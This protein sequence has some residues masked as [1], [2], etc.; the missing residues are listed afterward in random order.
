MSPSEIDRH[1]RASLHQ[2][3]SL[4]H[5]DAKLLEELE[6]DLIITQELCRVCA[7]SYDIV[8]RAVKRLRTDTRIV[9]LEPASLEDVFA[10]ISWIGEI[11]LHK[12]E[13]GALIA[14]LHARVL[15]LRKRAARAARRPRVLLLEWTDPP[16][17]AGH[18]IPELLELA[19]G[20]AVL[21]CPGANSQRLDW[22][23]IASADP[24]AVIVAPCG[25]DLS[26][27]RHALEELDAR[28]EW[29]SLRARRHGWVLAMDG[30]A[31]VS[32]P[33]P[34]LVDSAEIIAQWYTT[35]AEHAG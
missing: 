19:G 24:D 7:V 13:A 25:F 31:Y 1:V 33:G 34:R 10:H 28:S 18:W 23:A 3:S 16:M 22:S 5:L 2:G 35:L 29:N 9:S 32:R 17:S 14:S 8:D 11:T 21:G 15:A 30:N 12:L 4:Y 20:E 27:T 26:K 6:P